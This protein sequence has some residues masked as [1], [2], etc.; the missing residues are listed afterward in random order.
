[1]PPTST[2]AL[3]RLAPSHFPGLLPLN[4]FVFCLHKFTLS[5]SEIHISFLLWSLLWVSI[6]PMEIVPFFGFPL[7]HGT[8]FPCPC[9]IRRNVYTFL[10][11]ICL[12]VSLV[13]GLGGDPKTVGERIFLSYSCLLHPNLSVKTDSEETGCNHLFQ[14]V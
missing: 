9:T 11:F 14:G 13:L 12:K 3:P 8:R 2:P 10:M 1:M 5:L 4:P 7:S 6:V